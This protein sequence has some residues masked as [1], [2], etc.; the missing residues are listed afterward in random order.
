[1]VSEF[2]RNTYNDTVLNFMISGNVRGRFI[3]IDKSLN[4]I[5]SKQNYP[6]SVSGLVAEAIMLGVM[7]G[8]AMKLKWKLSLQIRGSGLIKLIAVD[9]FSPTDQDAVANVRAYAN[10]DPNISNKLEKLDFHLLGKGFFAVLIDQG[11]G[12]EPYQGITPLKGKSLAN[13]AESYFEQS[14]QLPTT[15][16][17]IVG[18][19]ATKGNIVTWKGGGIMLQQ[20][21]CKTKLQ[22]PFEESSSDMNFKKSKF[23]QEIVDLDSENWSRVNFLM[24]TT[25]E[26]E[27]VGPHIKPSEILNRLFHQESLQIFD[28][29]KVR[30]GCSCS[31][32]K[33]KK[34]LSIYSSKDI[35][36]MT[37]ENGTVTADCQFCGQHYV[38]DPSEI[39]FEVQG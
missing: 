20:L 13:C 30:F 8:Q 33:V 4:D 23:T 39:G 1:M 16:K 5:L 6:K 27:L 18:Q 34:T 37:T 19:S 14:E 9:Y 10:F 24:N 17:I 15:F 21:P 7:I 28:S 31:E 2:D 22:T 3:R 25:E 29:Q 32:E 12:T 11:A 38:L 36:S 26:L 35:K